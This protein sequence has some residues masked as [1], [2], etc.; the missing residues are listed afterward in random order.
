MK[1]ILH[2]LLFFTIN[3]FLYSKYLKN[4]YRFRKKVGYFPNIAF[5]S[6]YHEKMLWR[7]IF[8]HNPIFVIFCDKLATKRFVQER[9]PALKIP[10]TLWLETE[11]ALAFQHG[12]RDDQVIKIN[13]GYNFNFFTNTSNKSDYQSIMEKW[14]RQSYGVKKIEWAYTQV[15]KTI[16]AELFIK[17]SLST[18]L[19]EI[20]VRCTDGKALLCSVIL[21]N[22]TRNML[23]GYYDVNGKSVDADCKVAKV[24]K[25]DEDFVL[26]DAFFKAIHYAEILSKD[27]DYA[28]YDFI[29]DGHDLYAGEITVYPAAGLSHADLNDKNSFDAIINKNWDIKKSWFITTPQSGWHG[30][31]ANI[32]KQYRFTEIENAS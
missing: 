20:N 25:I 8:D 13:T 31:Y 3:V 18:G 17:T 7:K 22:K 1:K 32:L 10:E 24:G 4:I 30:F 26:P 27:I 15:K 12:L 23:V 16:F 29:Y 9:C 2:H 19:V 28:R 21:N 11:L 5:P 14:F 6:L